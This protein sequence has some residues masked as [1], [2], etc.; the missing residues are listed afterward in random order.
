MAKIE[1][2]P[3]SPNI[4]QSISILTAALSLSSFCQHLMGLYT[5]FWPFSCYCV[6]SFN[7]D[8]CLGFFKE[9]TSGSSVD[10]ING[11]TS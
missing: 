8:F 5:F 9:N 1:I 11:K 6:W 3:V 2:N 7:G 10:V 4:T